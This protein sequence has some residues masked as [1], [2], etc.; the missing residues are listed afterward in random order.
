VSLHVSIPYHHLLLWDYH[1]LPLSLEESERLASKGEGK[2]EPPQLEV[3]LNPGRWD[4]AGKRQEDFFKPIRGTWRNSFFLNSADG[5]PKQTKNVWVDFLKWLIQWQGIVIQ[6][7]SPS[8][9][10]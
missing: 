9:N 6:Y 3:Q 8:T 7:T 5:D 10:L 4:F 2:L 1:G